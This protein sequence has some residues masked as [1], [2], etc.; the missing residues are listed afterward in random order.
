VLAIQ[1]F[2]RNGASRIAYVDID[3]HH[4]DGVEHAFSG[5]HE[6]LLISVHEE[7]RWPRTGAL[8]DRGLGQVFNLP[9]PSGL[10]DD[11][12]ALIRDELILPLVANFRPDAVVLQ[13]GADAVTE[14]PQSRLALSNNAHWAIVAALMPVAA[15][16]LVLG[17]GGYNPWAVGRLWTGVWATLNGHEIPDVLPASAQGVLEALTWDGPVRRRHPE[18]HWISSL[19]DDPRQG[20][21][22]EIVRKRADVL[23]TRRPT[24]L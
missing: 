1:S 12:M 17:G 22:R 4:P 19:R 16:Y 2:R 6:T 15:R 13:C 11:E 24:W 8:E 23:A 21:I 10:N 18:P 3:A 20:P 7:N 14:D 9:V 5:D